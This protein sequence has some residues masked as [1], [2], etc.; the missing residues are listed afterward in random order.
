MKFIKYIFQKRKGAFVEFY[1]PV[2]WNPETHNVEQLKTLKD[3]SERWST[4]FVKI[5]DKFLYIKKPTCKLKRI[6]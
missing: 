4:R 6:S 1:V 5:T 3:K 2:C